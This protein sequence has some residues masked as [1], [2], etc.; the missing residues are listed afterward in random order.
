MRISVLTHMLHPIRSPYEGGLEMHTAMTVE[1]L[2]RRGHDVTVYARE[3][4]RLPGDVVAVLPAEGAGPGR[5]GAR[6]REEA[7]RRACAL[8]LDDDSDAVLNNSLSPVSYSHLTLPTK[9]IV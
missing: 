8:I 7:A 3:G 4:T 2:V 1:H 5:A 6:V 9:R